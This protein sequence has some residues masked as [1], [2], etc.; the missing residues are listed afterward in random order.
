MDSVTAEADGCKGFKNWIFVPTENM[1]CNLSAS[2][3]NSRTKK[4]I[5]LK[6]L[7]LAPL[8]TIQ[9]KTWGVHGRNMS[10]NDSDVG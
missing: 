3:G 4:V 9:D 7:V 10:L 2:S 8:I 6:T 5:S 1:Q